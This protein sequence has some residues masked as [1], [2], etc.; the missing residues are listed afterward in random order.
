MKG[1]TSTVPLVR[2]ISLFFSIWIKSLR[3]TKG[4]IGFL[5][6]THSA[7]NIKLTWALIS[8]IKP[9]T[10]YS[11]AFK[12]V[13]YLGIC[14]LLL[15]RSWSTYNRRMMRRHHIIASWKPHFLLLIG[16]IIISDLSLSVL[17][18]TVLDSDG[19]NIKSYVWI[20]FLH[21][22]RN[23]GTFCPVSTLY[24]IYNGVRGG[25]RDY[26]PSLSFFM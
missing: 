22:W 13:G 4:R 7:L 21:V 24:G 14:T 18:A 20:C 17:H 12:K 9:Q 15:L 2:D 6:P 3:T 11:P 5:S 25:F 1:M 10:D 16:E 23:N 19:R 26:K 8:R